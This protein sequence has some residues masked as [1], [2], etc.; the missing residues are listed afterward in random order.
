MMKI[1]KIIFIALALS[2]GSWLLAQ[3][4]AAEDKGGAVAMDGAFLRPVQKRDSVLIADQLDYGVLIKGLAEGTRLAFPDYSKGFA[5]SIEI[6]SGWKIDTVGVEKIKKTKDRLYD[7]EAKIRIVS[8]DEGQYELPRLAVVRNTPDGRTD[9]L[10]FNKMNLDVRTIPVDTTTFKPHDIK[11]QI[12]YPVTF[13]EVLPYI[14]GGLTAILLVAIAVRLIRKHRREKTGGVSNEPPHIIALRNLDKFRGNK[15]WAPDK[16]KTFYSGVTDA[17]REYISARYGFGAMEMTT[18]E[19]FRELNGQEVPKELYNDVK[20]LFECSDFVKYAKHTVSDE[21]NAKVLPLAVKFVTDTY[22]KV[23]DE[24][25]AKQAAE[26]S[27]IPA[28]DNK[29]NTD[30]IDREDDSAYMPK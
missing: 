16:Q 18:A 8:F 19:I 10:V 2:P 7:I 17:L 13:R 23:L 21:D 22:Q 12:R 20:G 9:T 29:E 15:F 14:A 4:H 26:A 11:G 27:E 28:A 25:A 30:S 6:V 3:N 1:L 5:D 24:E